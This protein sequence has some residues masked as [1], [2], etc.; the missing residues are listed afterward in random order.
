M[1]IAI[2]I[3]VNWMVWSNSGGGL[4]HSIGDDIKT[5]GKG[6]HGESSCETSLRKTCCNKKSVQSTYS[7]R[8]LWLDAHTNLSQIYHIR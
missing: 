2:T 6:G 1:G 7:T 3:T 5:G 4:T 8:C